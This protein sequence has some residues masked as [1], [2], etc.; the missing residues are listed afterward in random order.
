M[1]T[2]IPKLLY[3]AVKSGDLP[4]WEITTEKGEKIYYERELM[5]GYIPIGC[6]D[7]F[8]LGNATVMVFDVVN[9]S[10]CQEP[11]ILRAKDGY[12]APMSWYEKNE[13]SSRISQDDA[14]FSGEEFDVA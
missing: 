13:D 8:S 3:S 14:E 6:R 1:S 11:K 4:V 10:N 5:R 7:T 9:L 2:V 12:C